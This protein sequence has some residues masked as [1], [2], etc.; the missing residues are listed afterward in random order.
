M[1]K[2][3]KEGASPGSDERLFHSFDGTDI[4]VTHPDGSVAIVGET[5]RALPKKMWRLA[6]KNGCQTD[7]SIKPVDL[8]GLHAGDDAFTRRKA[9]KDAII[10]ALESD[11]ADEAYADAFTAADIPNVRWLEKRVGFS[12]TADERDDVWAE[13]QAETDADGGGD[14]TEDE[15]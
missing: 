7:T 8:P 2:Q 15:A 11:E 12:L 4:R 1:A 5:P 6:V 14:E 10:E 13:V 9:M 3:Q